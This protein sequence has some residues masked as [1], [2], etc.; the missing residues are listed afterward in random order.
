[1][2][3]GFMSIALVAA[4]TVAGT[5]VEAKEVKEDGNVF[6]ITEKGDT[7]SD[8]GDKY[9][10]HFST[11]HANNSDSIVS[12]DLINIGQKFLVGGK[13]FDT[14]L[15]FNPIV[16]LAPITQEVITYTETTQE[17]VYVAP[18]EV[19]YTQEVAQSPAPSTDDNWHRSNR[20]M[21]ETTNNYQWNWSNG[22]KGAYQFS[23]STWNATASAHG[24][25]PS[26]TSPANQDAMADA[27]AN[28]RYGGWGNVPTTG[29]W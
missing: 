12:P 10:I 2:Y 9:D 4:M 6:Y 14:K 24:L 16:E 23:E 17:E 29:G 15:V 8:I 3:V 21:V 27:Y 1:M 5:K 26:D 28:D 25:N 7:L 18:V 22:Y 11:I 19:T 13:E 20:R